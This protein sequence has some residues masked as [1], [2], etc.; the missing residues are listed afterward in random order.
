MAEVKGAGMKILDSKLWRRDLQ[1]V[2]DS[3]LGL[4]ALAGKSVLITGAT[5]LLC[6]PV[7]DILVHYNESHDRRIAIFVAGRSRQKAQERFGFAFER[8][9]FHFVPYDSLR[10]DN[11]LPDDIDYVIHGA[12]N[13]TPEMIAREPV[14]TMMANFIG[15]KC[16]LEYAVRQKT[17]RVLYVSSSEIYGIGAHD[18]PIKEDEYGYVDI[19]NARNSYSCC[20]RASETLCASF[21]EEHG[22]DSVIVRP[23]HIYGPTASPTDNRVSS[24]W[25]YRAAR[26]EDIVMKSNGLKL[27]SYCH[28]LDCASAMLTVLVSGKS[29]IP[30]N[31]SNPNS[32]ITI[33]RL[34]ELM[35]AAGGVELK[36]ESPTAAE[37]K[38][39]NPMDNSSLDSERLEQLGWSPH[40]TA[41]EGC[42]HTISILREMESINARG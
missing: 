9:Y 27:R 17:K 40:F 11:E 23:G 39:F 19:L 3:S 5:G 1:T 6:S 10:E 34:A 8:T 13:A 16:L 20:K 33:R 18:R 26:G 31:I 4:D 22:V 35:A 21:A 25:A 28:C 41:E 7:V 29:V 30:Y 36:M 14:E 15:L 42:A 37:A 32:I 38:F 24:V 2:V 12:G